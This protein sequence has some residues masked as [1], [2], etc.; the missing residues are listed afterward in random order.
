MDDKA[1][2]LLRHNKK[3]TKSMSIVSNWDK[4]QNLYITI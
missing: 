4:N 1:I 3:F 2:M